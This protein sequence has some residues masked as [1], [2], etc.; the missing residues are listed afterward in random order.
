MSQNS[1]KPANSF[2]LIGVLALIWNAIGV[3]A[4]LGQKFMTDEMKS[5]I[6]AEQLE[7]IENT[8]VWA[9]AAFA[10]AVWFGFI[11][12][13]FLLMR[14][15]LAKVLFMV[16]LVGILVQMIYNVFMIKSSEISGSNNLIIPLLTVCIGLFL[17]WHAKKSISD[18]MLS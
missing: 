14:K 8:P 10:I 2:W 7:I 16:S 11:A 12:C 9:T 3:M 1:N 13:V 18:G 15:K 17:I 6:P 5:K 4:Y